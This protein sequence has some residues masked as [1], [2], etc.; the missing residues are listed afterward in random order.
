VQNTNLIWV[1]GVPVSKHFDDPYFSADNGLAESRHVF[2]AGNNL[3]E[4]FCNGFHI[5]ETGFG[6]GL[7]LLA[8]WQ[9]WEQSGQKS[10]L[11]FT[12]FEAY[13]M[14]PENMAKALSKWPELNNFT[15]RFLAALQP[16]YSIDLP[17]LK[18]RMIL[19]DAAQTLPRWQGHADAWF[20]DG[21]SPDKNPDMWSDD[22]MQQV[23]LHSS[24]T[25]SFATYTAAGHIRR[26]LAKAG[27]TV[28][29]VK[30]HGKKR[31][32]TIGKMLHAK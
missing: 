23:G 19:G 28:E 9:L 10:A 24:K 21:F 11:G 5:G 8:A 27:F 4:R 20:L 25:A 2:L 17:T 6:T 14:S 29:R 32:M 31:H 3:P 12:S 15:Q 16:D 18:F 26:K 7:N 13:P 30:G 22:L 1:D